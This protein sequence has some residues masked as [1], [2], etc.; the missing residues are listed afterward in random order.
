MR[1]EGETIKLSAGDLVVVE[2]GEAHTFLES[3][4]DYL[5]FVLHVPGLAGEEAR[6]GK[7]LV[8]HGRLGL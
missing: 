4:A 1:V 3:S 5:H 2:P 8:P 6:A 7:V